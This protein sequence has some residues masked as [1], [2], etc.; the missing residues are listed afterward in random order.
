M[1]NLRAV[2]SPDLD[3]E[4]TNTAIV[5]LRAYTTAMAYSN[6]ERAAFNVAVQAWRARY[7]NA[8]SEEGPPA[9]ASIISTNGRT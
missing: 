3:L 8:S 1:P 7:P 2:S 5:V 6:S 4:T 9:V